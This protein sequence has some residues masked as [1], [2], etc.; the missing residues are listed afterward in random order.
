MVV[1]G[2]RDLIA[3]L[4][5]LDVH[6]AELVEAAGPWVYVIIAFT[7]FAETG[8]VVTPWLPGESL[9]L[10]S[11]TLAGAD[12]LDIRVLAPVLLLAAFLG[13]I[14]NYL[15]GRFVGGTFLRK[16]RRF[17]TPAQMARA[18]GFYARH[19]AAAIILGRYVP[20]VRTLA[21]FVAG[22][23]RLPFRLLV[24]YA[25]IAE[26]SWVAIFLGAGYLFGATRWV[27]DYLGI[28]LTAIVVASLLPGAVAY[29]IRRFRRGE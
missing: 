18:E 17:P 21:P 24:V 19:G 4:M 9:L 11:G 12:L 2:L 1:N 27:Q 5:N 13:D 10:T 3:Y 29:L 6:L 15:I 23:T 7:I 22:M 26:A 14:A 20:I 25:I 16:P 28:G 8:L